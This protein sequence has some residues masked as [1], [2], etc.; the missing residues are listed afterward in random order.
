M[1]I[2]SLKVFCDLA[3]TESF[4]KAAQINNVTQSAVSQQISALERAFKSL[5][6]ERSKKKFRLTREGQVLYDYSKQ[7]IQ[8]YESLHSRLQELKDII[9]GTIRVATIYSIGLHDLPPYI[10]RF[11]KSYPTVNIHVEYR[12]A[13]QVYEDVLSNVVD[14]G[15]VAYPVRDSKLE[16]VPLRKEPLVLIAHPQHPFAKQKSIK[17]KSL[18]GQKVIS[19]EP[20]IPTRKALDKILKEHDV[21]VN[22]VMEFDNVETVK[23]AVE[24]D[25]GISIVPQG[26]VTQEIAKQTL[27]AVTIEDGEFYRPLAAIFKKN[28]VLSP[29][30]KQFLAILKEPH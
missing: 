19:F 23:R 24:I 22:H 10:K 26:T 7:I 3:E 6:I 5:L 29:A 12:R 21:E 14:L 11:M 9:S 8:T 18:A 20:D 25:A 16:I 1:Q 4:T 28:K 30:M 13:N 27:V 17:L 15:L 2:D